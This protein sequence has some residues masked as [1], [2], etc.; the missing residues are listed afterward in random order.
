MPQWKKKPGRRSWIAGAVWL[1]VLGLGGCGGG[2]NGT[3]FSRPA[4]R[5][6][7]LPWRDLSI[8]VTDTTATVC[9][10]TR[11]AKTSQVFYGTD[12]NRLDQQSAPSSSLVTQHRV[13]LTGLT[14]QT[15]Y[16]VVGVSTDADG[17]KAV[18]T[19]LRSLV[20]HNGAVSQ[21]A[22]VSDRGGGARQIFMMG[23]DGSNPTPLTTLGGASPRWS[24][25][26]SCLVF[27]NRHSVNGVVTG[28][29]F[30]IRRD[31]TGLTNLTR[32]VLAETAQEAWS[33]SL[34]V[35]PDG[36]MKLAYAAASFRAQRAE[37]YCLDLDREGHPL[38]E[39]V[40]LTR[41][42]VLDDAPV[43]SPDGTRIAFVSNEGTARVALE[44]SG[45]RADTIRVRDSQ[46]REVA[47]DQYT[48]SASANELD[49][50]ASTNLF[51]QMVRIDYEYQDANSGEIKT[52]SFTR[53]V[54]YPNLEIFVMNADGSGRTNLISDDPHRPAADTSPTWAPDG[55]HL[56]FVSDRDGNLEIYTMSSN[57]S[58][59][60]NL[61]RH[62]A[63]DFDP[64]WSPDGQKIAFVSMRDG[65]IDIYAI[66]LDN[67]EVQNLTDFTSADVQPTWGP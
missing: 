47:P 9:W 29:L 30:L 38:G 42:E 65:L 21:I 51:G 58:G 4:V 34:W 53:T 18:R 44:R 6:D 49:F 40:R 24:S 33:P 22:F 35:A 3:S 56:A 36:T 15:T 26:G 20:T 59:R 14:P 5:I 13:T 63:A 41:N 10:V 2:G 7:E 31:G 19:K 62:S 37:I 11:E 27:Q 54:P 46:G 17:G 48:F 60:D 39:P 61:T 12:P 45:V 66:R 1:G 28:D 43:W 8:F 57:G 25:D 52:A 64:T 67:R 50:T 23:A 55:T 16:Y 32:S